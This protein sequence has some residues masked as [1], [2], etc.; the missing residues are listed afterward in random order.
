ML[1][2]H[3]SR[4]DVLLRLHPVLQRLNF[5]VLGRQV[6]AQLVVQGLHRIVALLAELRLGH[7]ALQVDVGDLGV[8]RKRLGWRR[9]LRGR[10]GRRRRL[11][12]LSAVGLARAAASGSAA[13]SS[14]PSRFRPPGVQLTARAIVDTCHWGQHLQFRNH[15]W[16]AP[17][18]PGGSHAAWTPD[19]AHI[20]DFEPARVQP[21]ESIRAGPGPDAG[22]VYR[23]SAAGQR[24]CARGIMAW[25]VVRRGREESACVD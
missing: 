3:G 13:A 7:D 1:V 2:E 11:R 16:T 19:G 20:V 23:P 21:S 22:Q 9:R 10:R 17:A 4:H 5:L 15:A 25:T 12:R 24:P 6:G 18:V 14:A 8:G